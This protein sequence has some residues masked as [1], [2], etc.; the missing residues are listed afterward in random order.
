MLGSIQMFKTMSSNPTLFILLLQMNEKLCSIKIYR[1]Y[2][3]YWA[4]ISF[5]LSILK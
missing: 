5:T 2:V 4:N 1:L 3:F